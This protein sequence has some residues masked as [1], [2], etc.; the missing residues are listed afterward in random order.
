MAQETTPPPALPAPPL[1]QGRLRLE[2][3]LRYVTSPH[4]REV[5]RGVWGNS[6]VTPA[7]C[8]FPLPDEFGKAP[9]KG[10][11]HGFAVAG[12]LSRQRK[13]PLCKG[14]CQ[15]SEAKLTG[16]LLYYHFTGSINQQFD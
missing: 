10:I 2:E 12:G 1:A 4:I 3:A 16:G 8:R 14:G 5:L 13:P 6:S 11:C 9:S 15:L 7:V